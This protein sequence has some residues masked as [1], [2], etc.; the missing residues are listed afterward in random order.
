MKKG[1]K[2]VPQHI[3][4]GHNYTE[5]SLR[6]LNFELSKF[7]YLALILYLKTLH[8]IQIGNSRLI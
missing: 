8:L 1:K 5:E 3:P 7:A 2:I 4:N 6:E